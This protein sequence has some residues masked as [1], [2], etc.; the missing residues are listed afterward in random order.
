MP[1]TDVACDNSLIPP[2]AYSTSF[3]PNFIVYVPLGS[4]TAI[5][6]TRDRGRLPATRL[7]S[8]WP[9]RRTRTSWSAP[10]SQAPTGGPDHRRRR[11]DLRSR[12]DRPAQSGNWF[13]TKRANLVGDAGPVAA[14]DLR[15]LERRRPDRVAAPGGQ[16]QVS[17]RRLPVDGHVPRRSIPSTCRASGACWTAT[18]RSSTPALAGNYLRPASRAPCLAVRSPDVHPHRPGRGQPGDLRRPA[19]SLPGGSDGARDLH[20]AVPAP[21]VRLDRVPAATTRAVPAHHRRTPTR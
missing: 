16:R 14:V 15:R 11:P 4:N 3:D 6:S 8:R 21:R 12:Q 1:R 2:W 7:R 13:V 10:S 17:L 18:A 5:T 19:T 9:T 20:L